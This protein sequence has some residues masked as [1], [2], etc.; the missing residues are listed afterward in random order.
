MKIDL[1]SNLQNIG[2]IF[3]GAVQ[4]TAD[5]A[6]ECSRSVF[7]TYD[8]NSLH[9]R[10]KKVASEIIERVSALIKEGKSDICRDA[11]L[12][13]LVT[14][15]GDIERDI[16]GYSKQEAKPENLVTSIIAKFRCSRSGVKKV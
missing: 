16:A 1:R 12:T 13:S 11:A 7:L 4:K 10:K 9:S 8:L 2:D 3:V 14:K 5:S 15:L 6:R